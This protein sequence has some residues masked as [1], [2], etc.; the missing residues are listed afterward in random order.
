MFQKGVQR[1]DDIHHSTKDSQD[2]AL[3]A[4]M[5]VYLCVTLESRG[6]LPWLSMVLTQ[7]LLTMV[8]AARVV[9]CCFTCSKKLDV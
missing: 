8:A 6:D 5:H 1:C 3:I 4:Q 2:G 9:C 7:N